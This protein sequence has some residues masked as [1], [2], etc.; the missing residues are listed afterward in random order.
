[1]IDEI[2][3]GHADLRERRLADRHPELRPE[4][5]QQVLHYCEQFER[6]AWLCAK[7]IREG[8]VTMQAGVGCL[9]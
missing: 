5:R 3:S 8:G 6:A 9:A 4:E 1:M 2:G 7:Q